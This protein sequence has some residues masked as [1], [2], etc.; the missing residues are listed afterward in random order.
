MSYLV[1]NPEDRFSRDEAHMVQCNFSYLARKHMQ[2]NT[3]DIH[4]DSKTHHQY[5]NFHCTST[6]IMGKLRFSMIHDR[7]IFLF[8]FSMLKVVSF[9]DLHDF[10][11]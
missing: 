11:D 10:N 7:S 4:K 9:V 8:F 2:G 5:Q 6:Q 1:A 3:R